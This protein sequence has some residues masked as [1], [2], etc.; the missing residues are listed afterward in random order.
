MRRAVLSQFLNK[1][2]F[3]THRYS[4]GT[5]ALAIL[6]AGCVDSSGPVSSLG[7]DAPSPNAGSEAENSTIDPAPVKPLPPLAR[8]AAF[9][10]DRVN[11]GEAVNL[12]VRFEYIDWSQIFPEYPRDDPENYTINCHLSVPDG[13]DL[14]SSPWWNFTLETP[15]DAQE[16]VFEFVARDAGNWTVRAIAQFAP[17]STSTAGASLEVLAES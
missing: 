14:R 5:L 15:G 4:A 6:F 7:V 13:L 2:R 16:H 17:H 9:G 3:A 12:S 1:H 10:R 11:V 8:S